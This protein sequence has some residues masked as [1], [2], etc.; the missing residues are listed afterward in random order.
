[1]Q[2]HT[3]EIFKGALTSLLSLLIKNTLSFDEFVQNLKKPIEGTEPNEVIEEFFT[4]S[5][6][7]I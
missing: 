1:M 7:I 2:K 6:I 3:L 5:N 4:K